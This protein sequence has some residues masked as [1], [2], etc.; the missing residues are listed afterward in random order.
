MAI[1]TVRVRA[2]SDIEAEFLERVARVVWCSIATVDARDRVRSRVVHPIWEGAVGWVMTRRQSPKAAHLA[3]SPYASL[4][5]ATDVARPFYADC[6]AAWADDPA[7]RR[8]VW[9]L[10][11]GAP[12]PLGYDPAPIFGQPD[13]LEMGLLRLTPWRVQLDDLPTRRRVWRAE[14]LR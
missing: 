9:D 13:N 6:T 2:F 3:H 7:T 5:Y 11:L 1:P 4:A 10:F 12:P 14:P 8:R